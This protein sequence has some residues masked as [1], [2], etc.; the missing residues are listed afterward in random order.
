M[1]KF[2]F[3]L[4]R[5]LDIRQKL[6]DEQKIVLAKASGDYQLEVNKKNR[7]LETVSH[8][9][10]SIKGKPP[11]INELRAFDKLL[12]DSDAAIRVIE[13]EMEKK[14]KIMEKELAKYTKL[15]QDKRAVEILKE[16][17]LNEHR[18]AQKREENMEIDEIGKNVFIR[19]N[20]PDN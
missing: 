18:E 8:F 15:K 11:D 4:Q 3:R 10:D 20:L 9:R 7:I 13:I 1:K 16:K 2:S 19:K 14:R 6:E 17:A 5:L 12:T